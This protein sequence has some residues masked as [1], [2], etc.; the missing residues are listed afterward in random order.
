MQYVH[1]RRLAVFA[2]N[3]V[4][5]LLTSEKAL[6][7]LE[8]ASKLPTASSFPDFL[9]FDSPLGRVVEPYFE[10]FGREVRTSTEDFQTSWIRLTLGNGSLE[11]TFAIWLG[12]TVVAWGLA[13][14]MN[15]LTVGTVKSAGKAVRT[16]VRQQLLVVKVSFMPKRIE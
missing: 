16:A 13:I 4:G 11:R 15:V 10:V 9:T 7:G 14:Y 8:G 5:D 6:E 2:Q 1:S 3:K 12:Y